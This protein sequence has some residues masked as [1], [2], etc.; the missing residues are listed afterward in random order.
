MKAHIFSDG[1]GIVTGTDD[2]EAARALLKSGFS[3]GQVSELAVFD[4]EGTVQT[5]RIV[6]AGPHDDDGNAWYWRPGYKSGV[7]GVTTAVVF[8][9]PAVRGLP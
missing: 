6:P 8:R 4:G 7:R 1:G 5:G 2:V 3:A 9:P